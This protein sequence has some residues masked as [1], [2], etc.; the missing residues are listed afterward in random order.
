VQVLASKGLIDGVLSVG[1]G[2]TTS[3]TTAVQQARTGALDWNSMRVETKMTKKDLQKTGVGPGTRVV[4]HRSRKSPLIFRGFIGGHAL[5]DKVGVAILLACAQELKR[6][7]QRLPGP[8]YFAATAEEEVGAAAGGFLAKKLGIET[9]VAIETG[10]AEKEYDVVNDGRPIV[11][12][13]DA[14]Y[15]YHKGLCDRLCAIADKLGIGA[16]RAAYSSAGTDASYA[17]R[18]GLLARCACLAFP[19]Q[20]THGFEIANISGIINTARVLV[21]YLLHR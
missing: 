14:G 18:S 15:L 3:E 12:Y 19:T 1:C 13:K 20:N 4:I 21:E 17:H 6:H 8:V 10:P 2:H 11:W 16:Q 5:D 7:K 9:L